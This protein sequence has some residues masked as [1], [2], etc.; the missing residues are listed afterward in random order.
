MWSR[1]LIVERI[2]GWARLY[3]EPPAGPDWNPTQARY[4][5]DETRA[6]RFEQADGHWPY[7]TTVVR[8]FGSWNAAIR[9]AGFEPRAANGGGGN[10]MR[11][12]A[13]TR[14]WGSPES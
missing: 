10:A 7:M 12:P 2:R 11:R 4:R 8:V 14:C 9:Q 3:G 1:E 13:S 6:R 5:G